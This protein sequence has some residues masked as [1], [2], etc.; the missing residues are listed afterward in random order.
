MAGSWWEGSWLKRA[1]AAVE[2][3]PAL[4]GAF[5]V[6][7]CGFFAAGALLTDNPD[8]NAELAVNA[9]VAMAA[10]PLG[11][12]VRNNAAESANPLWNQATPLEVSQPSL[13]QIQRYQG[14][15]QPFMNVNY[16]PAN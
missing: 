3:R 8:A 15:P 5:G 7:V 2:S 12:L 16:V 13:F 10:L 11:S 4:A 1:W 6:A 14:A 9:D